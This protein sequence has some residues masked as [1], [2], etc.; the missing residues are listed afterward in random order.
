M[1]KGVRQ[2]GSVVLDLG[3]GQPVRLQRL[4]HDA[5][6]LLRWSRTIQRRVCSSRDGGILPCCRL[7]ALWRQRWDQS[8]W[9]AELSRHLQRDGCR[10]AVD[11]QVDA[12]TA[13]RHRGESGHNPAGLVTGSF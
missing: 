11:Q 9:I 5:R 12:A 4:S 7:W 1:T 3:L 8:V 6:D 2:V 13:Q 10:D